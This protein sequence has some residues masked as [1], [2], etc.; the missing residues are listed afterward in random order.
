MV[1]VLQI[2]VLAACDSAVT[3]G[4]CFGWGKENIFFEIILNKNPKNKKYK[5]NSLQYIRFW[6]GI[7]VGTII[8]NV[9]GGDASKSACK[10]SKTRATKAQ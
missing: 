3:P 7:A 4:I 5:K 1:L 9:C 8:V 10:Q 6:F 2:F